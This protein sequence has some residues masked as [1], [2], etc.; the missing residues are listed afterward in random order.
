MRF[1]GYLVVTDSA[2]PLV[3]VSIVS[4]GQGSMIAAL[5]RDLAKCRRV[6]HIVVTHNIPENDIPLPDTLFA[7][8]T[9]IR[10]EC[11]AGF[12]ANHNKAFE[13]CDTELFAVLNPDI[14]IYEDPFVSLSE[15]LDAENDGLIAPAVVTPDG[16]VE[17]SARHFPTVFGLLRKLVG[18][19]DG[20]FIVRGANPCDVDWAAGMFL[21]F[22]TRA[23][24]DCGGFD[25][26][27]FLYYEDVDICARLWLMNRRVR[28]HP[29]VFVTH[30]AQRLSRRRLRY[31]VWHMC[32]MVR[33]L[34]KYFRRLPRL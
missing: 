5:L 27:F 1:T 18:Q 30:S 11:P 3:T 8:I 6:T 15:T 34:F 33:Y 2:L 12:A 9:T 32:S 24:R 10:N 23:F 28:F 14:R 29:E 7:R 4:H 22:P 16:L 17:D 31:A 19:G 26:G 20:R 21:L 25:E 13:C